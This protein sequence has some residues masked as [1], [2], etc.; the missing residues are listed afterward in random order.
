MPRSEIGQGAH[1]AFAMIVAEE[2][3]IDLASVIVEQPDADKRLGS[4]TTSGSGSIAGNFDPLRLA[5]ATAREILVAAAA[6]MWGVPGQECVASQGTVTHASSARTVR[7]GDLIERARSTPVPTAVELKDPADF[8]LIGTP[9][10]RLESVAVVTGKRLYG[11]DGRVP[12]MRFAAVARCP[13]AGGSPTT[14]ADSAARAVPGVVDVVRLPNGVAVLATNTWAAFRGRDQLT[15]EWNLGDNARW[16]SASIDAVLSSD[17]AALIP[18]RRVTQTNSIEAEYE[19]TY[20][21]HA[22]M[23]PMSSIARVDA[24]TC[25]L[26]APTQNPQVVQ[27]HVENAIGVPTTVHVLHEG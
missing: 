18:S 8:R 1:T 15:V 24:T 2:L 21:A 19:T 20:L 12:G 14:V 6:A 23:E 22:P 7:Y 13:V 26:W 16:S 10:K 9:V 4:Q 5:A 11:L 27:G 17:L 25:E 3:E